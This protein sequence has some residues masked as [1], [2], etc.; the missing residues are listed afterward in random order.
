MRLGEP[1]AIWRRGVKDGLLYKAD[2]VLDYAASGKLWEAPDKPPTFFTLREGARF[3]GITEQ[4]AN[5]IFPKETPAILIPDQASE[6]HRLYPESWLMAIRK[7]I[8]TGDIKVR[9]S[10]LTKPRMGA[11]NNVPARHRLAEDQS[12]ESHRLG[13]AVKSAPYAGIVW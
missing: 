3:V 4:V 7:L 10:S 2:R 1:D 6:P 8:A 12:Q 9:P 5:R 11:K 13:K